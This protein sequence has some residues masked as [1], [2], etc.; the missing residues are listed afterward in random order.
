[1]KGMRNL[2]VMSLGL[3]LLGGVTACAGTGGSMAGDDMMDKDKMMAEENT[4]SKG[5]IMAGK[6]A[7][8]N[9]EM[10]S[11]DG[12]TDEK[13]GM[14]QEMSAMLTGSKGHHAAGRAAFGM[15]MN[16]KQVLTL[17]ELKVDKVPDGYIYLARDGDWMHGVQL[18]MLKQFTG[19]VSFDLPDGVDP[20]DYDTVVIWCRKFNVEIGR[21]HFGKKM[22]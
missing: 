17:S 10:M 15:G 14:E 18:G 3:V 12:M 7:K 19:T 21:A 5:D 6:G 4:M 8:A 16:D 20:E 13:M 2:W 22:M 11:K 1:M 9:D